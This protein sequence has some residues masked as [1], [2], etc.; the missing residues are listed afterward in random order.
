M[1]GRIKALLR[2]GGLT[3]YDSAEKV[4]EC[5]APYVVAYDHGFEA[6]AGTKGMLGKHVYEVVCLTPYADVD[7]LPQLESR[8]RSLLADVDGLRLSATGGT[9]IEQTYQARAVAI[10]YTVCERAL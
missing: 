3:V 8:V 2:D 5:K 4:G 7:G 9:G 10:T 1:L 6:Q